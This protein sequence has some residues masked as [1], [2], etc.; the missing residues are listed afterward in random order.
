MNTAFDS[1][2]H[3][4]LEKVAGVVDDESRLWQ[5]QT[6]SDSRTTALDELEKKRD[7]GERRRYYADMQARNHPLTMIG[8]RP[9]I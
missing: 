5:M 6:L 3:A 8:R 4:G 7:P 1:G 9:R 2:I